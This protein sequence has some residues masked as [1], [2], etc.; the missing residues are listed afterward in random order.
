[1]TPSSSDN[2][3]PA[4]HAVTP[5]IRE[6]IRQR[7]ARIL[8]DPDRFTESGIETDPNPKLFK[9]RRAGNLD[10]TISQWADDKLVIDHNKIIDKESPPND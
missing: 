2:Q 1:M 8:Q 5:E 10:G 9:L 4:P 6:R 7:H 3:R